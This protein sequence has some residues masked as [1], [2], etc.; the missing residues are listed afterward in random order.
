VVYQGLEAHGEV[1]DAVFD[2]CLKGGVEQMDEM[3]VSLWL[4]RAAAVV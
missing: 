2:I 1:S 3:P 4:A